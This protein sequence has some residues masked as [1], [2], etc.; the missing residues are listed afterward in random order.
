MYTSHH[1][2]KKENPG[3]VVY[4]LSGFDRAQPDTRMRGFYPESDL[5]CVL[6]DVKQLLEM[7]VPVHIEVIDL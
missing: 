7:G 6:T 3:Q 2:C 4:L 1:Q 5:A